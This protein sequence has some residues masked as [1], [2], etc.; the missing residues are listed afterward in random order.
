NSK[1]TSPPAYTQQALILDPP[2]KKVF[3]GETFPVKVLVRTDREEANLIATKIT[4][5]KDL[6]KVSS[7]KKDEIV[8][9]QWVEEYFD[10]D[11]GEISLIGAVYNPPLKTDPAKPLTF[12]TINFTSKGEGIGEI[13]FAE[14]SAI[15][16]NETG[17]DTLINRHGLKL[18]VYQDTDKDGFADSLENKLKTSPTIVC[19]VNKGKVKV[20][21]W[22]P[23]LNLD[24]KVSGSD[25]SAMQSFM[26]SKKGVK[27]YN[28]RYDLNIDGKIDQTDVDII[29]QYINRVC[30]KPV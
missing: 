17:N 15:Y 4:F 27:K 25:L 16:S 26:K 1:A 2:Q 5:P 19:S 12:A 6:L 30:T 22:P 3:L 29:K 10:N 23:D 21:G 9:K 7:I 11:R 18:E 20:D 24:R 8:I 13:N 28:I 14:G